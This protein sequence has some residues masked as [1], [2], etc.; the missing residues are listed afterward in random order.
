M[1]LNLARDPFIKQTCSFVILG[2]KRIDRVNVNETYLLDSH[3]VRSRITFRSRITSLGYRQLGHVTTARPRSYYN[4]I[5]FVPLSVWSAYRWERSLTSL[6]VTSHKVVE[7]GITYRS[8]FVHLKRLIHQLKS[9]P[10]VVTSATC[11]NE[12]LRR[13][14]KITRLHISK[15]VWAAPRDMCRRESI[16]IEFTCRQ[17]FTR[18][19]TPE[20]KEFAKSRQP[21][22]VCLVFT[23]TATS[24]IKHAKTAR[25]ILDNMFEAKQ[26]AL[27][28]NAWSMTGED[29]KEEKLFKMNLVAGKIP[30]SEFA[31][32]VDV[33]TNWNELF[34]VLL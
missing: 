12:Y 20:V 31:R 17:Q 7:D 2:A 10:V 28:Q 22:E 18:K 32:S 14:D 11:N 5:S 26:I 3:W 21:G 19:L 34:L 6:R 23:N 29:A 27:P 1:T 13:F 4:G 16:K 15:R 25:I 8:E 30:E 33:D 9:V 24:A